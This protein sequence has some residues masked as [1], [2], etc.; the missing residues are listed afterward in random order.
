[1]RR[2]PEDDAGASE[3]CVPRRSL[4]SRGWEVLSFLSAA[5]LPATAPH[6]LRLR[7]AMLSAFAALSPRDHLRHLLR[8]SPAANTPCALFGHTG[9]HASTHWQAT[10][11]RALTGSS[12]P[13]VWEL[14]SGLL[15][16]DVLV[17][18]ASGDRGP[19]LRRPSL[20]F[21]KVRTVRGNSR[22][23]GKTWVSDRHGWRLVPRL[24]S[25]PPCG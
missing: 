23:L 19:L 11:C 7:G 12:Q 16:G 8:V 15:V 24:R 21:C 25:S 9:Q 3:E 1:M 20:A 17:L 22:E 6:P 4:G 10:C 5:A 14:R 13:A 2:R 18:G